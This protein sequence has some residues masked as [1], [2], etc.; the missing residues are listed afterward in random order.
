M[1][2]DGALV[3][4]CERLAV[5]LSRIGVCGKVEV[6]GVIHRV[7]VSSSNAEFC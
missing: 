2:G 6:F 7:V 3:D 5:L 1:C 4:V